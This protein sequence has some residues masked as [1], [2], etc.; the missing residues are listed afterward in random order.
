MTNLTEY[1]TE[2]IALSPQTCKW[3]S[4]PVQKEQEEEEAVRKFAAGQD[5]F[6]VGHASFEN[7][8]SHS[9]IVIVA[10]HTYRSGHETQQFQGMCR[11]GSSNVIMVEDTLGACV[12]VAKQWMISGS[13]N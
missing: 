4:S 8:W 1:M 6:S 3:A 10:I 2:C 11:T 12:T 9:D 13:A 5:V 7:Y